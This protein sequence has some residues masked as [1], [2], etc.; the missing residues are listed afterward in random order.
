M[1]KKVL[2]NERKRKRYQ[3]RIKYYKQNDE[4]I[5]NF[6]QQV[7]GG[8]MQTNEWPEQRN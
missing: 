5:K 2:P 6:F 7:R 3:D 8:S 4:L 1:Y